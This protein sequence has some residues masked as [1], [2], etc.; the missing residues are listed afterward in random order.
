M[1]DEN[2]KK[3]EVAVEAPKAEVENTS[4]E[5]KEEVVVEVVAEAPKAVAPKSEYHTS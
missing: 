4:P 3:E 2:A 5:V 1:A